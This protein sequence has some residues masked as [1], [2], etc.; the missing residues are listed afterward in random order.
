LKKPFSFCFKNEAKYMNIKPNVLFLA[1]TTHPA[2]AVADHIQ[3]ITFGREIQWHVINPIITKTLDKLDLTSFDAI[4]LHYSIKPYGYYYLSKSLQHKLAEYKGAKF[5]FLQDEYQRVNKVQQFIYNLGFH[6]LFT[7]VNE[8]F[9][10]KAYPDEKLKNLIKIPVLTAYVTDEMKQLGS[11][12]I[13]ER[14]IDVSYRGRRNDYWLGSLANEKALI[15]DQFVSRTREYNLVLDVSVEESDRVYGQKWLDLLKNSRAVLGT[16]SGA[17]IWD[18][19]SSIEMKTKKFLKANRSSSFDQVYHHILKPHDGFIIYS[20]ISPRVFE[21]AAT[22]TPMIMFPGSYS[23]VCKPNQ[24]YIL[25]EK[26]FS[27]LDE[28]LYKLKDSEYLQSLANYVF[29]DLIMSDKYSQ[30]Q[31]SNLVEREIIQL[32]TPK[33]SYLSSELIALQLNSNK[34]LYKRINTLRQFVTESSF[35]CDKFWSLLK[36]PEHNLNERI[37]TL[38]KGFKRYMVY[39]SARFTKQS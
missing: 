5:L 4:G 12:P 32:I 33:S 36:N 18:F 31:F 38:F 17:S 15:A 28:V 24:H 6:L 21:A 2:N 14:T 10:A 13:A 9:L 30:H 23:G 1:D 25:L 7:L 8:Q 3:A 19:D 27:N 22:K 35:V 39:L 29:D 37:N 20:A 26:D 34:V 11:T 16:E